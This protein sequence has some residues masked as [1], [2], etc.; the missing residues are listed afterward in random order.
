MAAEYLLKNWKLA[1]DL[2]TSNGKIFFAF[3]QPVAYYSKRRLEYLDLDAANKQN[4]Q[5]V[6][7][8]IRQRIKEEE[9]DWILDIS[10]IFDNEELIYIDG[11][12]IN[13]KG[14]DIVARRIFSLLTDAL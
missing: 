11:V 2:A 1:R 8:L 7:R 13:S 4:F 12:H 3:L 14:N 6:Y 10:D 9:L 5:A